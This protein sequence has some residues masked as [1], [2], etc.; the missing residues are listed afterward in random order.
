MVTNLSALTS[1]VNEGVLRRAGQIVLAH[2]KW[3]SDLLNLPRIDLRSQ[4]RRPS[5]ETSDLVARYLAGEAT[6]KDLEDAAIARAQAKRAGLYT[7]QDKAREMRA[8][9]A[10]IKR[11][12]KE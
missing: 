4:N 10:R 11:R 3:W 6:E 9:R 2:G 5:D 8:L 7:P 12:Q 1:W